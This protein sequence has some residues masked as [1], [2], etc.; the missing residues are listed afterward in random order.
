MTGEANKHGH[1]HEGRTVR[2]EIRIKATPEELWEAWAKP[3]GI[4]QW[5]VDRA[6]GDME[7]DPA[8]KWFFDAFQYEIPVEVYEADRG[9]YLA[10][11]G[12]SPSGPQRL[13]EVI[14]TQEGGACV[15][16]LANS[17]FA[18]GAEWDDEYE[19][20]DSGWQMALATLKVWIEGSKGERSH[21]FAMRPATFEYEILLPLYTTA[22][23]LQSWLANEVE[24][25][26]DE[27]REGATVRMSFDGG[28]VLSGTVLTR[29]ARELLI[30]WNEKGGV[31][32]LKCFAMGP[33]RAIALE[34]NAW[35]RSEGELDEVKAA[36]EAA[37]DRLAACLP[38]TTAS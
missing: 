35:G 24:F 9:R 8:I 30:G 14:I 37:L 20:V 23:G 3:D 36:M 28:A 22:S 1:K 15:L 18:D 12:P 31:L 17:G 27:L 7:K 26:G 19:G 21:H 4:A 33:Q 32:A 13:Q 38:A 25:D 2:K 6:E 10:F 5:F 16:R 29:T 34:F 11:G